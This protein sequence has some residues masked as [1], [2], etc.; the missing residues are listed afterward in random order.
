[1]GTLR[2]GVSTQFFLE[3]WVETLK[4]QP[5]TTSSNQS[6][7][8]P[9]KTAA[10]T[11]ELERVA[12]RHPYLIGYDTKLGGKGDE[13]GFFQAMNL[14]GSKKNCRFRPWKF[15]IDTNN[16]WVLK[17]YLLSKMGILGIC[18]NFRGC[19]LPLTNRLHLKMD[20]LEPTFN[21]AY[22]QGLSLFY[23]LHLL[24][25]CIRRLPLADG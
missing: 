18:V 23:D 17:M 15:N 22:F 20:G 8:I 11:E 9:S 10:K 25:W 13:F 7:K 12:C 6:T 3:K 1:M 21:P 2:A 19:T 5:S 14:G 16:W 24:F 4:P